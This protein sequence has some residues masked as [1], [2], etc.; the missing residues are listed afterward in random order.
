MSNKPREEQI[1]ECVT[2]LAEAFRQRV[3][4]MTFRTYDIGLSDLDINDVKRAVVKAIRECKFM[5]TVRELRELCGVSET[6]IDRKDRPLLAWAAVRYAM[7]KVGAYDTTTFT[8]PVVNATIRQ[9]GDWPKLCETRSA[10]LHWLEKSF[11]KTY[12]ALY[13]AKL[14]EEQTRPLPGLTEIDNVRNG[15]TA[16]PVPVARV[17]CLTVE[18][19]QTEPVRRLH[20][21]P[22]AGRRLPSPDAAVKTLA[23]SL[24]SVVS[25]DVQEPIKKARDSERPPMRTREQQTAELKRLAN[26]NGDHSRVG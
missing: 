10:D 8:D 16:A 12:T 7:S 22:T 24:P 18:G 14:S 17:R 21:L 13:G 3:S 5:P 15:Y 6:S 2:I 19:D 23:T 25:D 26:V 9:L 4:E 11:C 20:R 1:A